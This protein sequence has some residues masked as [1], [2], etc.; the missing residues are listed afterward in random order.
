MS[1]KGTSLKVLSAAAAVSFGLGLVAC[2]NDAKTAGG[3]PSGTE[4]GNAIIAQIYS[5]NTPAAHARVKL[6][7]RESIDGVAYTAE[8]EENGSVRMEG[9]ANGNY[10]LEAS[11]DDKALQLNVEINDAEVDLG[12]AKLEKTA[13]VSGQVEGNGIVKVRGMDHVAVVENGNFDISAL[14]AGPL[15]LVFI[16]SDSSSDTTSSYI[17]TSAGEKAKATT[18]ANESV[19]LLLDDFQDS[20]YQNRFMPAHTYDGGWWYFDFDPKNVTTEFVKNNRFALENDNGNIVAHAAATFGDTYEDSTG[21]NRWPWAVIGVELGKSDKQLCNDISSVDSVAFMA[22]GSG[23]I[24]FTLIDETQKDGEREILKFEF[25]LSED[26][27][28]YSIPL[29]ALVMPGYSLTCV[30][31]L[32]WKLASPVAATIENPTPAIEIWLDDI[33]L[34]GGDRLT[35]WDK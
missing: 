18:F 32:D 2:S 17:K 34:I 5:G 16:P 26:W 8:T 20:N 7:E 6:I 9:I 23:N 30:N 13:T 14:P 22:K 28:R 10:T 27:D 4:A 21:T 12:T 19:Y 1:N 11:L 3:G 24:I 35:I 29:Q 15:S 31:Q 33:M 25:A